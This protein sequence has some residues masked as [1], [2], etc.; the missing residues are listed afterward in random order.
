MIGLNAKDKIKARQISFLVLFLL[1]ALSLLAGCGQGPAKSAKPAEPAKEGTQAEPKLLRVGLVFDVGGRGDKS[2]NDGAYAGLEA[3]KKEMNDQLELKYLEPAGGG[4]NREQLLRLLAQE[5]FDLI[6]G[7]GFMFTDSIRKV[8]K[9]FPQTK[10]ALVDGYIAGLN[11]D[12]NIVCLLYREQEG[13]FLVGSMAAMKSASGKIGFV[14]GMQIPLIEKF[15]VGYIAGARYVKP[16]ITVVSDYVGTTGDA[17]KDPVKGKELAL[18]QINSGADI[19]FAAAGS[20]G[21]GV[22]EAVVAHKKLFIGVDSDQ[23]LNASAE[24]RPFILT[25]MLKRVDVAVRNTIHHVAVQSFRGG[26]QEYGLKE[27]GVNYADN[28]Y[29]RAIVAPFKSKLEE[30]K[31]RILAGD[32]KV[33]ISRKELK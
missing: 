2:F 3:A 7:V 33:P 13:A 11:P 31:N 16:N 18:K 6:F 5:K 1:I 32:I 23:S 25:S 4:E 12:S 9:D 10:F 26:Y 20:S 21:L 30:I 28:E 24:Q 27:N 15:E 22:L 14:G 29:N 8:A 17:F 19:V